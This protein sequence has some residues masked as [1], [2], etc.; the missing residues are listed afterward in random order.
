MI[1]DDEDLSFDTV[2]SRIAE[3]ASQINSLKIK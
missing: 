3:I 2:L 1:I